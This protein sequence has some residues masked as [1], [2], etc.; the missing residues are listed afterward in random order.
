MKLDID[1][2]KNYGIMLSGGL[3]SAILLYLLINQEPLIKIQ[4]FTID[5]TDGASRYAESLIDHFNKKFSLS[6][7]K[8]IYV[9]NPKAHHRSQSTTAVIDIFNNYPVDHLFIGINQNP[10]ELNHLP[11]APNRDKGSKDPRII[12][13]FVDF[14]KTDILKIMVEHGQEDLM[15][16][17]HSC[18]E[19]SIGRCNQCWQC[20]ERAWSFSS[21]EM[22]DNGKL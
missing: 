22:I 21:I 12:F 14:L 10:P 16:I 1:L 20:T 6:I 18:T 2:N 17:T 15:Y 19:Q 8:T 4:P 7:S 3:D 9:G 5:K 13:P 11:G